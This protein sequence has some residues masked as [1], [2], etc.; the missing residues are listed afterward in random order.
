MDTSNSS[1]L[2]SLSKMLSQPLIVK[3]ADE[4]VAINVNATLE[5]DGDVIYRKVMR[6]RSNVS[7][8]NAARNGETSLKPAL[9]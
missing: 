1:A 6:H 3:F 2:A 9:T 5:L 8:E 4:K 7:Q